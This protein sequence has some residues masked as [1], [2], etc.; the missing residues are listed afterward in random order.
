MVE[1]NC[2]SNLKVLVLECT[3]SINNYSINYY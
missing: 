3:L 1:I 2:Q